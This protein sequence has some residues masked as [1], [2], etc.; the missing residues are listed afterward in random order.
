MVKFISF[1]T[2]LFLA[3]AFILGIL[4]APS[5]LARTQ[6][7]LNQ[8]ESPTNFPLMSEIDPLR[9][10]TSSV[11]TI[12]LPLI[13]VP[14][15]SVKKG[16]GIVTPPACTDLKTL[17]A[18]WYLNWTISP[19]KSCKEEDKA[20]FVPRISSAG[21]I[22]RLPIAI[23]NAKASGWLI[24]FNEPNLPWQAN[25]SPGQGAILWKQIE[26]AA[27]PAG[28]KL[29]SPTPN[30]WAPGLHG[31]PYGHQWTW[32]MVSEYQARYG[33]KPHFD[34]LGWNVYGNSGSEL[35][36]FLVARR[37][38]ALKRGYN[39][40]FWVL[41]YGGKCSGVMSDNQV[42]MASA[43]PWLATTSWISRYAWF[44]NR[45][46]GSGTNQAGHQSCSLLNP[47]TG[48]PT[49]LGQTYRGF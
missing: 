4:P 20:R 44:A 21:A 35:T 32:F 46:D 31:H 38:E 5:I 24:G 45:I 41:E 39:V 48:K 15:P 30:P 2:S 17:R 33:K 37:Q 29:V 27:R 23:A 1:S 28:I 13:G 49:I 18:T 26:D 36:S 16:V 43:T 22:E 40:P 12:H 25:I 34:A 6:S 3:C 10:T 9:F 11:F 47:V 19:D 14:L 7:P 8:T 42:V